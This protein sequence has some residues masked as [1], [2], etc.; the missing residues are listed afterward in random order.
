MCAAQGRTEPAGAM[1]STQAGRVR[2]TPVGAVRSAPVVTIRSAPVGAMRSARLASGTNTRGVVL[3]SALGRAP[4]HLYPA[5]RLGRS[6]SGLSV[7]KSVCLSYAPALRRAYCA[8]RSGRVL[9]GFLGS[10]AFLGSQG[11][12][13][14]PRSQG[15]HGLACCLFGVPPTARNRVRRA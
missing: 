6:R 11:S 4:L 5:L 12:Q 13:A 10:Q 8:L 1:R 2:L 14:F 3:C 15:L 7:S 9:Q